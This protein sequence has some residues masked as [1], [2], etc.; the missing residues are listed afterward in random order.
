MRKIKRAKIKKMSIALVVLGILMLLFVL[1]CDWYI[2]SSTRHQVYDDINDIPANRVALVL[3]TAPTLRAG[4]RNPYFVYRIQAAGELYRACKVQHF[5]LS[6]DNGTAS[7]NEPAEMRK[8]LL[9]SGVPDSVITL[10]Y[11]GF[12]TLDSVVRGKEVFQQPAFTIVSQPFHNARAL[13]LARA[14]GIDAVAYNATDVNLPGGDKTH[15]REIAARCKAVLDV[16]FGKR[17]KFL[18]DKITIGA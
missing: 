9:A 16:W 12:R 14:Y 2:D 6:G 10:D 13:Y 15:W 17:P 3:G 1:G 7:Y 8:A 5:I 18:G 4:V 11:A